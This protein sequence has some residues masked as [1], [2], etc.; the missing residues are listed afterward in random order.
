MIMIGLMIIVIVIVKVIVMVIVITRI[1]LLTFN[2]QLPSKSIMDRKTT[3]V[4]LPVIKCTRY[5]N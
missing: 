1:A 3:E 5:P 4:N 2:L